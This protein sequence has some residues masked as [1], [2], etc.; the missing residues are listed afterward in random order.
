M[1]TN[2]KEIENNFRSSISGSNVK[3]LYVHKKGKAP[4]PPVKPFET[5]TIDT[6]LNA[7]PHVPYFTQTQNYYPKETEL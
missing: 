7:T 2:L 6:S 5:S 4:Q 3:R 1:R